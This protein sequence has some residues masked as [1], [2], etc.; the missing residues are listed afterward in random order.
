MRDRRVR[1]LAAVLAVVALSGC[2]GTSAEVGSDRPGPANF[3]GTVV[4]NPPVALP[5]AML[6][7]TT[8]AVVD[9]RTVSRAPIT[10]TVFAYTTCLDECPL[11]VSSVAAALRGLPAQEREAVQLLV[12][13]ADPARDTP[14]ALRRWLDRFDS[15]FQ[16][17][18]GEPETLDRIARKLYV[19]LDLPTGAPT[20]DGDD[21]AH[22]V[23][24]WAFGADDRSRMV[25]SGSPT[26]GALRR[27][28][29][30]L[31]AQEGLS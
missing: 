7:D 22:G 26:P 1:A 23:Q 29:A 3:S 9:V 30:A 21:I 14:Q 28:L 18:T 17:L 25:W 15:R 5:A 8:G 20:S 13:S 10:L 16:G 27:D 4:D 2:A 11:T 6:V 24:I 31:L 12:L 19:P